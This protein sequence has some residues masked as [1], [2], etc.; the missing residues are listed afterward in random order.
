MKTWNYSRTDTMPISYI[1]IMIRSAGA[2][3]PPEYSYRNLIVRAQC[4]IQMWLSGNCRASLVVSVSS[5]T[6]LARL[7]H[8]SLQQP[9]EHSTVMVVFLFVLF[10]CIPVTVTDHHSTK[11]GLLSH[12]SPLHLTVSECLSWTAVMPVSLAL[13]V[14][15]LSNFGAWNKP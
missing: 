9:L 8:L 13:W 14:L 10:S 5:K 1:V 6:W 3:F 12:I 2:K 7:I 11:V 4:G 15:E